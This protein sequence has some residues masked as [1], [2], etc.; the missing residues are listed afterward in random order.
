MPASIVIELQALNSGSLESSHGRFLH[1]IWF[2]GLRIADPATAQK[3]HKKRICQLQPFTV[4]PLMGISMDNQGTYH[5]YRGQRA[6]FRVTTLTDDLSELLPVSIEVIR[7]KRV[8][9][10]DTNNGYK[11]QITGVFTRPEQHL[12]AGSISY[13]NLV[14]CVESSEPPLDWTLG[15]YTPMTLHGNQFFIPLPEKLIRSWLRK[16]NRFAPI[17]EASNN[18]NGK[19]NWQTSRSVLNQRYNENEQPEVISEFLEKCYKYLSE[20]RSSLETLEIRYHSESLTC[21]L[22]FIKIKDHGRSLVRRQTINLLTYYSFFCGTGYKTTQ[23]L[24]QTMVPADEFHQGLH[25]N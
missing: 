23:G 20:E 4:S 1:A 12:W 24:G 25:W 10:I 16:W 8:L 19:K 5:F 6:W 11:W 15:F 14:N 21:S 18:Q 17:I 22:G 13:E 7:E 9:V 3:L 2:Q